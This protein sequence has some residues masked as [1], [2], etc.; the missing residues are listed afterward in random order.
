MI[1]SQSEMLLCRRGGGSLMPQ[2][3]SFFEMPKSIT[4]D[5]TAFIPAN[6]DGRPGQCKKQAN[7]AR[8]ADLLLPLKYARMPNS[9]EVGNICA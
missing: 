6:L 3:Q 7:T 5:F 8:S 9:K 2:S 4:Q 1:Q